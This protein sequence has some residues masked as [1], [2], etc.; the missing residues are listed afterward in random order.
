MNEDN[1]IP[2]I[3]GYVSVKEAAEILNVSDTMV[4]YYIENKQLPAERAGGTLLIRL[5][6]IEK[7]Q[8]RPVGR[9]RTRT[10]GWRR[11]TR[12]NVLFVS[13]IYVRIRV[14]KQESLMAKLEEI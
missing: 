9:P 2:N 13:S 12:D 14:G 4:Y 10:P 3:S 7:F 11:S 1:D 6:E 5:D 8:Q